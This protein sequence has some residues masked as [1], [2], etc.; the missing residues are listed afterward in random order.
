MHRFRSKPEDIGRA[1]VKSNS[2]KLVPLSALVKVTPSSAP[3]TISHFNGVLSTT[4]MGAPA[5]GYSSGEIISKMEKYGDTIL[6][7]G[8]TYDWDGLYLQQK[9]VGSKAFLIIAFAL[10]LVYLILSA[11]YEKWVLPI[12]NYACCSIRYFGCPIRLCGLFRS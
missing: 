1:W 8:S 9:L 4:V 6:P 2:G 12:L 3:L 7:D 5:E 10:I 11:L